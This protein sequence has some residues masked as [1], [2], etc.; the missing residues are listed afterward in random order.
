MDKLSTS[1][2]VAFIVPNLAFAVNL[3]ASQGSWVTL[4]YATEN[5]SARVD[6]VASLVDGAA[7]ERAEVDFFFLFLRPRLGVTLDIAVLVDNVT[8][9]VDCV[10]DEP[11]RVTFGELANTVSVVVFDETILDHTE[12]L[13]ASEG[14]FLALGALVGRN[15]FAATDNLA[16]ITVDETL[17][18]RL[19]SSQ[20]SK[21]A[22]NELSDRD[23]F[24]VDEVTLLVQGEA[25]EN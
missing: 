11:L 3:L 18:V 6:N 2:D 7:S 12:T 19:A 21:I 10:S 1:N 17:A 22:L 8:V 25:I 23:A 4:S 13:V 14:A 5:G 9:F 15:D 24:A 16:G 20:L